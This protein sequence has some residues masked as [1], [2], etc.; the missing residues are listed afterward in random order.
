MAK[1]KS[2]QSPTIGVHYLGGMVESGTGFVIKEYQNTY[3]NGHF[4]LTFDGL[5][6]ADVTDRWMAEAIIAAAEVK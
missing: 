5:I 3:M 2:K 6:I 4:E 1:K